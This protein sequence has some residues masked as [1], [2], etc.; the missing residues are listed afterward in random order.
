MASLLQD[1]RKYYEALPLF[2]TAL[3]IAVRA[4]GEKHQ[5][6]ASAL[7]SL[8]GCYQMMKN[9]NEA[10]PLYERALRIQQEMLGQNHSDVALTLNGMN[11]HIKK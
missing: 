8:G 6:V 3:D 1:Q 9:Y 10:I 4:F 11:E 7:T 2:K 5:D